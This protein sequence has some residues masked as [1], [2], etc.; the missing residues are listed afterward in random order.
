MLAGEDQLIVYDVLSGKLGFD[1]E[2]LA[3][4]TRW[5]LTA[6]ATNAK[7]RQRRANTAQN[8]QAKQPRLSTWLVI[9]ARKL[10]AYTYW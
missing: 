2:T 7:N 5:Q 9:L 1:N 8:N 10:V 4:N 6:I 3:G